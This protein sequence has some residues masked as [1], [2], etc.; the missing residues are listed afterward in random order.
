LT[1]YMAGGFGRRF[2]RWKQ[3][4]TEQRWKRSSTSIRRSLEPDE[5]MLAEWGS[6]LGEARRSSRRQERE[7]VQTTIAPSVKI[8]KIGNGVVPMQIYGQGSYQLHCWRA[9]HG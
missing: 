9:D 5:Q 1:P 4:F 7:G 3:L 6:E 8:E 2:R